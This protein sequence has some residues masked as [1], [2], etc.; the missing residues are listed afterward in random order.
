M[1][2]DSNSSFEI[3]LSFSVKAMAPSP[4]SVG[5]AKLGSHTDEAS[6]D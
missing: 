1:S 4:C 6:V 3:L 2:N 5:T